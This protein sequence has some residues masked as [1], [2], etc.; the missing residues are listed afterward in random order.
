MRVN[1]SFVLV[2]VLGLCLC[3]D[4]TEARRRKLRNIRKIRDANPP[5]VSPMV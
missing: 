2:L 3:I 5:C 4:F 1:H